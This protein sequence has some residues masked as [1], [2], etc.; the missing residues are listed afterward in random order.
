M[1]NR[2]RKKKTD[3]PNPDELAT[4]K[5]ADISVHEVV[6]DERT[7]KILG[8]AILIFTL[9]LFLSFTSYLFTWQEDQDKVHQFGIKIFAT[10]DVRL[11]NLLGVLG[12]YT[13]HIFMYKG[14]G[15]AAFLFCSLFFVIGINLLFGK[16]IFSLTRSLRYVIVGLI[17]L[18]LSFAFF[19]KSAAFSWGGAV[20]NL[21]S[22]WLVKWIGSFGTGTII[23]LAAFSYFIWRFN[24]TFTW[25]QEFFNN[26]FSK[27]EQ[28][29][30]INSFE[31]SLEEE[32]TINVNDELETSAH[33]TTTEIDEP[34]SNNKLKGGGK[35]VAVIMPEQPEENVNELTNFDLTENTNSE[36]LNTHF[37]DNTATLNDT[38]TNSLPLTINEALAKEE[39]IADNNLDLEI[40]PIVEEEIT[41][42]EDTPTM[43]DNTIVEAINDE[44]TALEERSDELATEHYD[45]TLDLRDYRY[46]SIDLLETH[47]S[48]KIIHDPAEL[49]ANKNQIIATLNNYDIAIQRISATV[50]PTVT[51]YEIVPAPGVRISRIKNLEDDIALSLAALGIRIIAPIP[52]KGTVGIEVPNVNKRVVSMKTLLSSEKFQHNNY[53]LPIAIGKKIDNENFI[54]DLAAMPHL[55]MAG[56]TGQG[57]SVGLNAVLVSLL[58]KKHPSQLKFVLVD[59]KK[60]ELSLYRIIEKHFLAKLPG[61]EESIIT[62]TKK[63]VHTLNALC[64]EM[65]NRYDLLK[66]AGCRNIR[67]YNEKFTQRKLSPK[68]GHQYLPFIVLVID[69]FADLIMTAGKE[70]EMPIAR[71]AQLARAIGI[72]LIIATQRPSVNIITGTIKANFPARIAFKVSSKIDSRTIL[73]TGGAEQLIGKGDMLISYNGEVTRLQCAFVDTPEVENICEFI[74]EQRGYPDA[75]LLPEY[76][77]EKEEAGKEFDLDNRDALFEDA[78]R[79]IVQ[80]QVGSTSLIQRRMKLGYNRAGRLMDQLEQAGIVGPNAGSKAREVR[81]KSETELQEYLDSLN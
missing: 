48:E 12:A 2:L 60:V 46:P 7:I 80:N 38:L 8:F 40:K 71:L 44:S 27:K 63:V 70:V 14:F 49:E 35:L 31:D 17:V 22:N 74:G 21:M 77:D 1:A 10:D 3:A 65:D 53:S 32:T 16:K 26:L 66:E 43:E 56:A 72:H 30:T 67:E 68:K 42:T 25:P 54:V 64:I 5:V 19:G 41:A 13:A 15:I 51:L 6:K 37:T 58:Y 11:S 57:K 47:G 59:P 34:K 79:L 61:E 39:P 62:D 33:N 76:V 28:E 75:F 45:P 36:E 29:N 4:D 52:G 24:P 50:G 78:A 9:F 81:F 20:G 23:L 18:S 69:E 55:L 73:D